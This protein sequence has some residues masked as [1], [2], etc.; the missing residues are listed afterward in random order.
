MCETK[1]N[2]MTEYVTRKHASLKPKGKWN[3]ARIAG[4]APLISVKHVQVNL[5]IST[6]FWT[7]GFAVLT[8]TSHSGLSSL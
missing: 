1:K 6:H 4:T 8:K 7:A 3:Q 5:V 2:G